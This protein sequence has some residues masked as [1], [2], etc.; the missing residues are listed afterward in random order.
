MTPGKGFGWPKFLKLVSNKIRFKLKLWKSTNIF[1]KI[2]ELFLLLFSN[3]Y[4][5]KSDMLSIVIEDGREAPWK[6]NILEYSLE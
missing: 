4:K 2:R 1:Y 5:T 3:V 6:P